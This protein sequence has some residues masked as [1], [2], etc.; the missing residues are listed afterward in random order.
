MDS[1]AQ[2]IYVFVCHHPSLA[3]AGLLDVEIAARPA[4]ID[5]PVIN[6]GAGRP[7]SLP[8]TMTVGRMR[9]RSSGTG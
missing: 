5:D 6:R 9:T 3:D 4:N 8:S 1:Q 2:I 7:S